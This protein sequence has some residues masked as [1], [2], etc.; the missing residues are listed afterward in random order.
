MPKIFSLFLKILHRKQKKGKY[1]AQN[2]PNV[3]KGIDFVQFIWLCAQKI[4]PLRAISE[5]ALVFTHY[6]IIWH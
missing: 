2:A 1:N 3:R 5:K 6:Y 4:V